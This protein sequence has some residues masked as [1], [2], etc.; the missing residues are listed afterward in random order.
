MRSFRTGIAVVVVSLALA[1][2]GQNPDSAYEAEA[3][4]DVAEMA[5][6]D[7][8]PENQFGFS[9]ATEQGPSFSPSPSGDEIARQDAQGAASDARRA[10][11]DPQ[12]QSSAAEAPQIAYSYAVGFRVDADELPAFQQ[13]HVDLCESMGTDCRILS[14]AQSGTEEYGYGEVQLQVVA[15]KAAGFSNQLRSS[16]DGV[17][18]E[19]VSYGIS[20]EDLSDNIIDTEARLVG[21]RALRDRLMEVLRTRQ[22]TVAEIVEA[23]R[24]VAEVNEEIDAAASRLAT[25]RTRVAFSN[26]D[27]EYSPEQGVI[28][29]GF[30]APV[31]EAFASAGSIVGMVFATIIYALAALIPLGIL[32][33]GI[34]WLWRKVKPRLAE[35][36][37][38]N[39]PEPEISPEETTP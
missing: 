2:C 11:G 17:E 25:M 21:R 35:A 7:E 36:P 30:W 16:A 34:V 39:S 32:I 29:T 20:G 31:G 18:A 9:Q 19:Q 6:T 4:S 10:G 23:E 8:V 28:R 22:G 3:A 15:S 26:F 13:R 24:G 27:I 37:D 5:A 12:E 14:L 33:I 38:G 1:G